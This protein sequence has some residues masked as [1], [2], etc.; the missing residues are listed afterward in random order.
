MVVR[1]KLV[2]IFASMMMV[3]V[4]VFLILSNLVMRAGLRLGTLVSGREVLIGAERMLDVR[5]L[6]RH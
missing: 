6:H 1:T 3:M 4:A 2:V 5:A